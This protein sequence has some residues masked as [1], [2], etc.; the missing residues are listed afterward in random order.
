LK[1]FLES[2]IINAVLF[3][4]TTQKINLP[5]II[6]GGKKC[7]RLE[8]SVNDNQISV[9]VLL[10]GMVIIFAV[11][12][13]LLL[14][15]K[16]YSSVQKLKQGP[17]ESCKSCEE[18][19]KSSIQKGRGEPSVA[20]QTM[21]RPFTSNQQVSGEI[22]AVLSAAAQT[23]LASSQKA[24]IPGEVLAAIS[25]AVYTIYGAEVAVQNVS[26]SVEPQKSSRHQTEHKNRRSR[27]AWAQAGIF[28][29]TRPF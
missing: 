2:V 22:L 10:T 28:Q 16:A 27:S 7:M 6:F 14:V 11:L 21:N 5:N 4:I 18:S 8:S 1:S 12:V 25:G 19:E 26:R 23:E 13:L 3:L 29:N 15:M 17:E 24:Q 20:V 9:T